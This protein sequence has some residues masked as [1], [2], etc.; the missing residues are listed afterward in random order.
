MKAKSV[1]DSPRDQ[2]A[3]DIGGGAFVMYGMM[4]SPEM[5]E[6]IQSYLNEHSLSFSFLM[7]KLISDFFGD[8]NE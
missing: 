7:N 6:N 5:D 8:Q 3:E 4:I 1:E 2:E